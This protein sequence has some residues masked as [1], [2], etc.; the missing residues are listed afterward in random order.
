V[1]KLN[2]EIKKA[3]A[4]PEVGEH[5]AKDGAE[6]VGNTPAQFRDFLSTEIT[7]WRELVKHAGVRVE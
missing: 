5:M 7:K 3:L 1:Q 6:P 4:A 2:A